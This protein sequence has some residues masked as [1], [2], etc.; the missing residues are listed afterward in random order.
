MM[1]ARRAHLAVI[2]WLVAA[3]C[4]GII[5]GPSAARPGGGGVPR[6]GEPVA[7]IGHASAADGVRRLT[8]VEYHNTVEALFG[9]GLGYRDALAPDTHVEGY[10][11]VAE[12]LTVSPA[13]LEGWAQ[14]AASIADAALASPDALGRYLACDAAILPPPGRPRSLVQRGG[15]LVCSYN[16]NCYRPDTSVSYPNNRNGDTPGWVHYEESVPAPGRYAITLDAH[17]DGF[18]PTLPSVIRIDGRSGEVA[19]LTVDGDAY[20]P[21][22]F[23]LDA[24]EAGVQPLTIHWESPIVT[25]GRRVYIR[26]ITLEGPIDEGAASYAGARRECG[27]AFADALGERAFRRPLASAERDL[28]HAAFDEGSRTSFWDGL[29]LVI[30]LVLQSPQFLYLIE[31]G[32]PVDGHPGYYALDAWQLASR[33]SYLAWQAPPDDAL[34]DAAR[35]GELARADVL[36]AHAERLFSDARARESVR[37]FYGQWLELDGIDRLTRSAD[38][39]PELTSEVRAA[40]A[41]EARA[42]LD[43]AIWESGLDLAGVLTARHSF[44]SAPLATIYGIDAPGDAFARVVLPPERRGLLTQPGILAVHSQSNQTSPVQR[45]VFVLERILC[46]DLPPPPE[47]AA[48]VPPSLDAP[49]APAPRTTRERW[50]AHSADPACASCHRQI[51]PVGF[52]FEAFDAIGRHRTEELDQPID[53]RGGIPSHG[54]DDGSIANAAELVE[55]L[56]ALPEAGECLARQWLRFGLGRL[57]RDTDAS[58]L[59]SLGASLE[60]DGIRAMLLSIVDTDA[61]RHRVVLEE[62]TR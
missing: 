45:G 22:R 5:E 30:E 11:R 2:V 49:D 25:P 50:A 41:G 32:T 15:D 62:V 35:S 58:A 60:A 51:D 20:A 61:F 34:I 55:T 54:Y 13:H 48:A 16:A 57:E 43:D 24:A 12:A 52:T 8:H 37:R 7:G 10:D 14:T 6:P 27:R 29:R 38:Q 19:R 28:L 36:R 59:Q 39:F 9:T 26:T 21:Y 4:D 1:S 44:V 56:A 42:F 40:M 18:F 3:A 53:T 33:L 46:V 23:V 17:V 47:A 31:T